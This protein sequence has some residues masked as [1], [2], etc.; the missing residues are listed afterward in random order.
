MRREPAALN[1]LGEGVLDV[2][3]VEVEADGGRGADNAIA[4]DDDELPVLE[5][6]DMM[7]IVRRLEPFGIVESRKASA[8]QLLE[9]FGV[10]DP[11]LH[12]EKAV[13]EPPVVP[14]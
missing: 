9:L 1:D 7:S 13:R 6:L 12:D 11:G 5:E 4:V 14:H 10:L 8:L 2:L 3:E